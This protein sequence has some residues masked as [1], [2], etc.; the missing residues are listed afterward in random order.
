MWR[1]PHPRVNKLATAAS[2]TPELNSA[3]NNASNHESNNESNQGLSQLPAALA[4]IGYIA[5]FINQF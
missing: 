2:C 5:I 3:S 4:A 1:K